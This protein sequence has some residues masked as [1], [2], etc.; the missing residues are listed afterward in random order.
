[1]EMSEATNEKLA[2]ENAELQQRAGRLEA[3]VE[4]LEAR[5]KKLEPKVV[6]PLP[7]ELRVARGE[8][9]P[10]FIEQMAGFG[11]RRHGANQWPFT[12]DRQSTAGGIQVFK[13]GQ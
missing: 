9:V 5:I 4:S 1:M 10:T 2:A 3:T 13:R 6:P 12:L 7:V 8:R 11:S